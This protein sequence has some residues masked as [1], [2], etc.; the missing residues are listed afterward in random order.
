[1][2][3]FDTIKNYFAPGYDKRLVD[4]FKDAELLSSLSREAGFIVASNKKEYYY[5]FPLEDN[6]INLAR[7][8]FR[9]NGIPMQVHVSTYHYHPQKALR[10]LRNS[11]VK[12][13][14]RKRF[15]ESVDTE[16][17]KMLQDEINAQKA[18]I[19]RQM[20]GIVK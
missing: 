18:I 9:R 19:A 1:M 8:L 16:N 11:V 5:Y 20:K 17:V 3:F 15:I 2:T 12:N 10:V 4:S 6:D 13:E 7:F 14:A